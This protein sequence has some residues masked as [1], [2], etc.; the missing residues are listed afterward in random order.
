[1]PA[2]V[3]LVDDDPDFRE[4][5]GTMLTAGGIF[6]VAEAA[7]VAAALIAAHDHR[8]DSALVD[9]GLPTATG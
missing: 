9:V 2:T 4:L 7:T 8:P 5:A 1:M 6:V 3:L